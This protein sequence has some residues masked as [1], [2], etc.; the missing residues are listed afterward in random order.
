MLAKYT[1]SP[2]QVD[3]AVLKDGEETTEL[4]ADPAGP[5]AG[6]VFRIGFDPK[7]NMKQ[8]GIRMFS[9]TIKS[10]INIHRNDDIPLIFHML[11]TERNGQGFS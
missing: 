11:Q 6:L 3:A 5:L 4:K 9:G 8:V 1:P 10:D 7:S 2:D